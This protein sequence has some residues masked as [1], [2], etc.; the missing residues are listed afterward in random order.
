MTI[1]RR[2]PWQ[3]LLTLIGGLAGLL[4]TAT[5]AEKVVVQLPYTHQFQFAGYYAAQTR[6][7]F[8]EEGLEVELRPGDPQHRPVEEVL[9]GRVHYGETA[10]S[11]LLARLRGAPLVAVAVVFQHS[12]MVLVVRPEVHTLADLAGRRIAA[13][14]ANRFP[15]LPAMLWAEGLKPGQWETVPQNWNLLALQ[16]PGIDA[17][18]GFVTTT[19]YDLEQLGIKFHLLRP[20][21]YGVDF[22]GDT[23]FTT[24]EEAARHPARVLA[25]RRALQ[26]GWDYALEHPAELIDWI[27]GSLPE[28][29]KFVTRERLRFEAAAT[30]GLISA[31]LVE[32]G[33]MNPGRWQK[34][35]DS[36]VQMGLVK[37][38]RRLQGFV[39]TEPEPWWRKWGP[40]LGVA[41]TGLA[42]ITALVLFTVWRL[43][44]L[45]ER[46][47]RQLQ[48][49]EAQQREFFD[50]APAYIVVEDYTALTSKLDGLRAAGV[51]DLRAHLQE[52]PALVRELFSDKRVVAAN[53]AALARTGFANVAE[54]NRRMSEVM[55][56]QALDMFVEELAAIWEGRDQ[57]TVEKVYQVKGSETVHALLNWSVGRKE[58]KRDLTRVRLVFTD[59]TE[60]K[61]AAAAL[62]ASEERY[63]DL[64]E[65]AVGGIY[66]STPEG[67]FIEIN[68]AL[69][70]MLGFASPQELVEYDRRQGGA[71]LYVQPGRR[72]EFL[73]QLEANGGVVR[74]FESEVRTKD[75][76]TV[77]ISENVRQVRDAAGRV[78]YHEG[79]VTDITEQKRAGLA[80][81]ASEERYRQLFESAVGGVY[82]SSPQGYFIEANPALAR[83]LGFD[84]P[85]EL[86]AHDQKQWGAAFYVRP[87]RQAEFVALIQR[88]GRVT[89]F[90]SEVHCRDGSTIW[91]S[92]NTRAVHDETG[93]LLYNE[94][95]VS[96]ITPRRRLE[97]EMLRASKLE[98]V[99]ILAGGIAHDFNNILTVV[100]GN[101]TLAE[102]DPQVQGAVGRMLRE[103]KRATLR[104][105]DLTQQLL[106]FAK[107]GEP[108]RM[109]IDLPEL[110]RE[111]ASF[112]LH[113]SKTR[114]EFDLAPDLWP[115]NVDKGQISQVVQ[116]L[117]I[118]SVQAMPAGGIVGIRAVN[119]PN[120]DG[121]NGQPSAGDYV[122]ISVEDAGSGIAP[123]NLA[124]IFDPYFTTK[125]QGSG[126][127]LATVYSVVKK[128]G[129]HIEVQSDPGR[130]TVFHLWLPAAAVAVPS[131][132]TATPFDGKVEARVLFM[133][134][135]ESI[136]GMAELFFERLGAQADFAVDGAEALMKYQHA[137]E[138]GRPFDIVI[139]DLT[140]P[141]GMGG[142]QAMERLRQLDPDVTAIVSSGYSHDPV[143]SHYRSYGFRGILP[144]PYGLDQLHRALLEVLP[145]G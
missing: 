106:T 70:R 9:A 114:A 4:A 17:M 73:A 5:A 26:R 23:L 47:T 133:D 87:D 126:L 139:M 93:K 102:M 34:M 21:D 22:Y 6:G 36:L 100:L 141:G 20:A 134:D 33:H 135:E 2:T 19:P 35:A 18:G 43:R 64:F 51:T 7:F 79:F 72:A 143:L 63:R 45:V 85:A 59:I 131:G 113:G 13:E 31:N 41:M 109:A 124:K 91:I 129:G 83:M 127:G 14:P 16:E 69:A 61:K 29:P 137:R 103:A 56:E 142:R 30:A 58:G 27:L 112:A 62:Q 118:N 99:G 105:R 94:G 65:N 66:R 3:L 25:M 110:L 107:G 117:V 120:P 8:L 44:R 78:L 82:R 76:H 71:P 136:R 119:A 53:A 92:E 98:A 108:V 95:F 54:M 97:E 125:Q 116:N 123:E 40:W 86:I 84:S 37:D 104:A 67:V 12:P 111:S 39:F 88:H 145:R 42:L 49:S 138:A 121:R 128:H 144:K 75:G 28:R 46:R 52:R 57:L 38:A 132:S 140:V 130:G 48:E 50:Q 11:V 80:L 77:W 74:N 115:A 90:E 96:D 60:L 68:T 81:H 10:N 101:I 1:R 89:N 32:V 55:T 15:E 24:E 122:K